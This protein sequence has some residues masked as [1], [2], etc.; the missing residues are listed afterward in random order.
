MPQIEQEHQRHFIKVNFSKQEVEYILMNEAVK[1]LKA[2]GVIMAEGAITHAAA[3]T[4]FGSVSVSVEIVPQKSTSE[5][6]E[7]PRL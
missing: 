5:L 6:E 4:T 2:T 1:A 7:S 3:S